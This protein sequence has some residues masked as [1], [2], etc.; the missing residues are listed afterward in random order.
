M[1]VP[2][3]PPFVST[4]LRELRDFR[5]RQRGTRSCRGIS[6]MRLP[7]GISAHRWREILQ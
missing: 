5:N 4:G 7:C 1:R 6:Q 2:P 3:S